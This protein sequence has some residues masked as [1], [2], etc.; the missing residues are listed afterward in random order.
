MGAF[1]SSEQVKKVIEMNS[2]LLGTMAGGAADCYYWER[3]LNMEC[4][5]YEMR[6]KE[7]ISISAASK[8]LQN[9][10]YSYKDKG[11]SM[12]T[13]IAGW[14]KKGPQLYYIDNDGTRLKG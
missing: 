5:L 1:I 13:M 4:R 2:Y 12:G 7:R 10:V 8:I 14:D 3:Y 9:I 11:L 6:N